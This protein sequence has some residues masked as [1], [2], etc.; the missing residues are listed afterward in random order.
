MNEFAELRA[1]VASIEG[2]SFAD[3]AKALDTSRMTV[4]RRIERLGEEVGQPLIAR[5]GAALS[6]TPAGQRLHEEAR[7]VLDA[8]AAL[9]EAARSPARAETTWAVE[10]E[11]L[12]FVAQTLVPRR[13]ESETLRLEADPKPLVGVRRGRAALVARTTRPTGPWPV[14]S[15]GEI[16]EVVAASP[17]YL[18]EHGAPQSLADLARHRV[19]AVLGTPVWPA[20]GRGW[21]TVDPQVWL[22]GTSDVEAAVRAGAG[23]GLVRRSPD[24]I[25]V[26]PAELGRSVPVWLVGEAE[27]GEPPPAG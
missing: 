21:L 8:Y 1:L 9:M 23:V 16:E 11:L 14:R 18:A 22:P 24:L 7:S 6:A 12:G 4:A 17:D 19:I 10:P 5:D 2:G 20:R 25:P 26:L 15:V 13:S 3:A 27:A